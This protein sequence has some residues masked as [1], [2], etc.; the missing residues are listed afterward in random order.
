MVMGTGTLAAGS[1]ITR[2][3]VSRTG[4]PSGA[5]APSG[6][7]TGLRTYTANVV[8][9][10]AFGATPSITLNWN[11]G[12]NLA[13]NLPGLVVMQST[14]GITGGWNVRSTG[15]GLGAIP[16][17]GSRASATVAPGPIVFGS[18]MYFG[19]ATTTV[20]PAALAY[21]VTRSTGIS[22]TSI[23]GSGNNYS[24]PSNNTDDNITNAVDLTT[25]P[26]G[27]TTFTYQ[28][29][30]ITAAKAS[31]N[32]FVALN[33]TETSNG[34]TNNFTG[35]AGT[36]VAAFWD[37]LITVPNNTSAAS[38]N[39]AMQW[40]VIG[41]V[42][43]SRQIVFEWRNMSFFGAAG[44][45]MAFQII[46]NETGNTIQ[47][48]YGLFQG[49][50]G[51]NNHRPTYTVGI[52]GS[53]C[54]AN[55]QPGEVFAQ[56]YENFNLFS[57]AFTAGANQG[58]N[59]L[60]NYPECNSRLSFTPG[61]Y[62]P[63]A[64]PSITA[65]ANDDVAGALPLAALLAF[66]TNLCGYYY[67]SRGATASPQAV[68]SGNAND[69]VW[70]K[71]TPDPDP[72]NPPNAFQYVVKLYASGGYTPTFEVLD[73]TFNPLGTPV[74]VVG[75]P[76]GSPQATI[77]GLT[78]G[79]E[80]FIRV[81]HNEGPSS[82]TGLLSAVVS[83]GSVVSSFVTGGVF[84]AGYSSTTS[85]SFNGSR[86][87]I[88]GGG[89]Q[90]AVI[91]VNFAGGGISTFNIGSGG[92][93]YTSA[94]TMTVE[95]PAWGPMGDFGIVVFQYLTPQPNNL[96]AAVTTLTV[97]TGSCS[98]SLTGQYTV[99][100]IDIPGPVLA[101]TCGGVGNG[102]PDDDLWYRFLANSNNATVQ[103]QGV[104]NFSPVFQVYT[105]TANILD[106]DPTAFTHLT[107]SN[108]PG[109]NG[110]ATASFTTTPGT[111]YWVRAYSPVTGNTDPLATFNI[112]VFSLPPFA[113]T[114]SQTTGTYADITGG[115]VVTL[116]NTDDAMYHSA[117][118]STSA[119]TQIGFNIGFPFNYQGL[120][121]N[122]FVINTN[123]WIKLG[124]AAIDFGTVTGYNV[125]SGT[126]PN[127]IAGYNGD[128][129]GDNG[130]SELRYQ[131]VGV[132]PNRELVVQYK[133][134][135][136]FGGA[137]TTELL[138]NFQIRLHEN[139]NV[140]IVYGPSTLQASGTRYIGIK[141]AGAS[142]AAF[143][144]NA[145]TTGI[146]VAT[147][148]TGD[149]SKTTFQDG[150]GGGNVISSTLNPS[151]LNN[152]SQTFTPNPC[153][154]DIPVTA[155]PTLTAYNN[156]DL[157]WTAAI[158]EVNG[159]DVRYRLGSDG[160]GG[161][162]TASVGTGVLTLNV[163]TL[164][165]ASV[166]IYEVRTRCSVTDKSEWSVA[167]SF[168]TPAAP[169]DVQVSALVAP[170]A[171][172]LTCFSNA[173]TVTVTVRNVGSNTRTA[174][175]N[176]PLNVTVT[177]PIPAVLNET[178]TLGANLAQNATVNY[179]FTGTVDMTSTGTYT[180]NAE[181]NFP[182]DD[183]T[184]ND[185][186][187]PAVTIDGYAPNVPAP[188]YSQG[189]N[190]VA[191]GLVTQTVSGPQGWSLT[192]G[193]TALR[194]SAPL[195][196][197]SPQEGAG[198]GIYNSIAAGTSTGRL[199]TPCFNVPTCYE[200]AFRH[201][202]WDAQNNAAGTAVRVSTNGGTTWSA[203]LDIYN[204]TE[205]KDEGTSVLQY[206]A[207][208]PAP[209]WQE[210]SVN[211]GAYAGQ[212]VRV[213]FEGSNPAGGI[214]RFGVD[215]VVVREQ[216][217]DD[218][219]AQ[220]LVAP[221]SN[222]TCGI[223]A[224]AVIIRVRNFGCN[225]QSNIPVS[226]TVAG[227]T[228]ASLSG[229]IVGPIAGNGGFVD[230]NIGSINTVASGTYT[231]SASTS[232]P[233]D[234][235]LSNDNLPGVPVVF[236]QN[237]NI[238]NTIVPQNVVF[239]T[240]TNAA[241]SGTASVSIPQSVFSNATVL[242]VADGIN[243]K[244]D[245]G[246][247]TTSPI[248]IST[249]P[250][251][252][253]AN[254]VKSI[255]I[256]ATHGYSTDLDF[257]IQAPNGTIYNLH[258][259][260]STAAGTNITGM[261][262]VASGSPSVTTGSAPYNGNW[263]PQTPFSAYTGPANGTW[264][265]RVYDNWSFL[266]GTLDNWS[267]EFGSV[268]T[269]VTWTCPL[270]PPAP[271]AF[272]LV[273][274]TPP[275]TV[276]AVAAIGATYP[277]GVY[278]ITLQATD[279]Q[280]CFSEEEEVL[281]VFTTNNWL[282]INDGADNYNDPANW[283]SSPAPP[284]NLVAVEIKPGTPFPPK[285]SGT[286][287]SGNF[288]I[289]SGATLQ[290]TA[291]TG[292]LNVANAFIGDNVSVTGPGRVVMSGTTGQ[293]IGGV[294]EFENLEINKT[295][296]VVN[297][298]GTARLNGVLTM[299]S[300]TSSLNVSTGNLILTSN[301]SNTAKIAPV[302]AGATISGNVTMQRY[303]PW[304][305]PGDQGGWFFLGSPI[306]GKNFTDYSDDFK[307]YGPASAYGSQGGGIYAVGVQ[308]TTIFE[309]LQANHNITQD[310]AQK[311]G[312]TAPSGN[313]QNGK[314]YR[315]FISR[316]SMGGIPT[317]DNVGTVLTGNLNFPTL[318]R[319]EYANCQPDVSPATV[320][321]T[322]GNRG[323]N[324]VGN[325]YPCA[326]DW[327]AAGWT[328]PASMNNA[329][330]TWNKAAGSYQVYLGT[331]GTPG[332]SLGGTSIVSLATP[333][334][335]I[336]SSQGFFVKLRNPGTYTATLQSTEAVKTLATS[337][338]FVRTATANNQVRIRMQH[339]S[340][341]DYRFD[342]MIRFDQAAS[343]NFDMNKDVD[344]L[345]GQSFDFYMLADNGEGLL[346]NT[347]PVPA[348]SKVMPMVVNYKG[349]IGTFRFSFLEQESLTN[350]AQIYLK[351]NFLGTLSS[352]ASNPVYAFTVNATDGS[353]AS[354][355]FEIVISPSSVTGINRVLDGVGFGIYPNPVE[356]TSNFT[357]AL[358]SDI[359][360]GAQ[361][362]ITDVLGKVVFTNEMV[363]KAGELSEKSLQPKLAAGVY[364]VKVVSN[365]KTFTEKL[366]VR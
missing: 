208:T 2:V 275:A 329:I 175:E 157:N 222:S 114:Y 279:D 87:R 45:N 224:A 341:A 101:N 37:D 198:Y 42:A 221:V 80:Y 215:N 178:L 72:V 71:F 238:T 276:P 12:D 192:T 58:S 170:L 314:G 226:V 91:G 301:A 233:G 328:K 223:P 33:G 95:S 240:G 31:T 168:T 343:Y 265:L 69:D 64:A 112:C 136:A 217:L 130:T 49:F 296:G 313:I 201:S 318:T 93:G 174:G 16:T 162:T 360:G 110:L 172:G 348:E 151:G 50:N 61:A 366:V 156:V 173:M 271:V 255:T 18:N 289:F 19:F 218:V 188:T 88:T 315:V 35:L 144:V 122:Q 90:G 247:V 308:H 166:Y 48:N 22:Y 75:T 213:A 257:E 291:G 203:P 41:A 26:G 357:V 249:L 324:L 261:R 84:G 266:T 74:C 21:N 53:F 196:N 302:P 100:S 237:P 158:G 295:A 3:T 5:V 96:P 59:G 231:I 125:M 153:T 181:T 340:N 264:I 187:S 109:G 335:V 361:V 164:D 300:A 142:T 209:I 106:V 108:N 116:G 244:G 55:P 235:R 102:N 304:T 323:W 321:C 11:A 207:S 312:W 252:T 146:S 17:T 337:G 241:V 118:E 54:S 148:V 253:L 228:P 269:N 176:I 256:N 344:A 77:T 150:T 76:G 320:A 133:D 282:G 1:D 97:Q 149:L 92:Y 24:W 120:N 79:L 263:V 85:G 365:G 230:F 212:T 359:D 273:N 259:N 280:G 356:G 272:P 68:C 177:G 13:G 44:P 197:L 254:A 184:I 147:L 288:T 326:V 152:I 246:P 60:L 127:V 322:E 99:N 199:I 251:G 258:T 189:L 46:L 267:I 8:S 15:S 204:V 362:S 243:N 103:M 38:L 29:A 169:N 242:P 325:P 277:V 216:I 67:T 52:R 121:Y 287:N 179:T 183:A 23:I 78:P 185:G 234:Q 309:Y 63:P 30:V 171:N 358:R 36:A 342:G 286:G 248:T 283:Q 190:A 206:R 229:T 303:L 339:N 186:L 239:A 193:A 10:T 117:G 214:T 143:N 299:G 210:F 7:P 349:Q 132:A 104:N 232:L 9:G 126:E 6:T 155:A 351:D 40:Q 34:V 73:N 211:L 346:M 182:T 43:G 159:Y 194:T 305:G 82:T 70:F 81:Y 307:V 135:K 167:R 200:I 137:P 140:N 364:T 274:N 145:R 51:T 311:I 310:T 347:V 355:R 236:K 98:S 260:A 154:A 123:G 138:I 202:R 139:G 160:V 4:A 268:L 180:F 14:T 285:L 306:S 161:Y 131:T 219:A 350:G 338:S 62:V 284:N 27:P 245:R 119:D 205:S 191:T 195:A 56:E 281:T 319:N 290:F 107:C 333:P 278:P 66:P 113:Y 225:S 292:R 32:G 317:L 363:A 115:A 141:G 94:P 134:W 47:V 352:V 262:F 330:Y 86:V 332:V 220:A 327:D 165:P 331:T 353:N 111:Y 294:T 336:P 105:G 25:I 39:A 89:G 83:G 297:V 354:D 20:L 65:P 227:P 334:N 270:C 163:T 129:D 128:L 124:N 28:G 57:N 298:T 293:T 345:S 250:G 316:P